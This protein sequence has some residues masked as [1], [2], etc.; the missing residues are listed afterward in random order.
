MSH[1]Q[2]VSS[3]DAV[4]A[5]RRRYRRS[6]LAMPWVGGILC[7]S[8][9][10]LLA[11]APARATVVHRFL[12]TFGEPGSAA[13]Q[14]K[15]PTYIAANDSIGLTPAAGDVYVIDSG[16]ARVERFSA[17]G[18]YLGQ[19]DGSG[20]YEVEGK[21]ETGP[22]APTGS[23]V[24][25]QEIA[26]DDSNSPGDPSSE[27]VYVIDE[28]HGVID[29]FTSTG[30]YVGQI[31]G[32]K[33]GPF[34]AGQGRA[35]SLTG[36]AVDSTGNLWVETE[37][38]PIYSFTDAVVN[39]EASEHSTEQGGGDKLLVGPESLLIFSAVTGRFV[40]T[41][42]SGKTLSNPFGGDQE[43]AVG[44]LDPLHGEVYLSDRKAIQ[45][46]D[47]NG[48][49]IESDRS[50]ALAPSFGAGH[51]TLNAGLGVNASN[52]TVYAT[53]VATDTVSVFEALTLPTVTLGEPTGRAPRGAIL[54]GTVNPEGKAV[55]ACAF[56]YDTRPY[57]QGEAAH[58]A[59]A[60]CSPAIVGSAGT[61]PIAVSASVGGLTPQRTYY[62]RL[63][64][65]NA[66]GRD[67]S[68]GAELFTGPRLGGEWALA[69]AS[70]SVTLRAQVDPNGGD[71]HYYFQ[72]GPS[73]AYGSYAP[74]EPPGTDIGSAEGAQ[75]VGAHLQGLEATA[76]YHYRFVAVQGGEE[77]A[78][79]DQTFTTQT[80]SATGAG[81]VDGRE[82]ELVSPPDK[83]GALIEVTEQG[84]PVQA[85][86]DG[87]GISY[88]AKGTKFGEQSRGHVTVAT[89][90]SKRAG[91]GWRSTDLTLPGSLPETGESAVG[92]A[93]YQ[94]E[95][96]LFSPQL[97]RAVVEPQ[98]GTPPLSP[99]AS[100]RTIYLRDDENDSFLA[101]VN[102]ANVPGGT[103]IQ[104]TG[105]GTQTEPNA[106]HV[107]FLTATPDLKHVVFKTPVALTPEATDEEHPT[108]S[109]EADP[110]EPHCYYPSQRIQWNI[111]EWSDGE[112]KLV[113]VLPGKA[114][115]AHG[116][117]PTAPGVRLAGKINVSGSGHGGA[118]RAISA[119]GRFIAWAWGQ[120]YTTEERQIY[121]GL[122][123][124]DMVEESTTRVGGAAAV[125]QTMSS[126]GAR[127][128]YLEGGELY[129]YDHASGKTTSLTAGHGGS[130][131]SGEVQETVS[132]VSE[133]GSY[134]YFVARGVL[135]SGGTRGEDNLYVSHDTPDGWATSWIATLAADDKPSWYATEDF[136]VPF[137]ADVSSRVSPDG[138]FLA[139]MSERPLTGYDNV[140][141]TSGQRDEEVFLY[142]AREGT[143]VCGSCN[144]TE[145]RPSG[146]LDAHEAQLVI[147]R[148]EVWTA[149][150]SDPY[151][152]RRD[153]WLA[154]SI[155]GWDNVS[156]DSPS[157]Q[158]RY[159][160]DSGRLFFD[161]AD[162]LVPHDTNGVED[163]YEFEP[164]GV[165]G[166]TSAT[167]SGTEVYVRELAGR[168]VGGCIGLLSAGTSGAESAFYDASESGDDVFFATRSKLV[169][170]DFDNGYDVYDAHVCTSAVPCAPEAVSPPP[171][172]SG[173]ACKGPPTPQPALFG[174]PASATFSGIGNVLVAPPSSAKQGHSAN[175]RKLATAL[176][177][178][179]RWRGK[180]RATCERQ[181]HRRYG[182]K[183]ARRTRRSGR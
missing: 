137:L 50:G 173:D 101:L 83:K 87:S 17:A 145:A 60:D 85:A 93:K 132:N 175:A 117:Y 119:D 115:V 27:D 28:G 32:T 131:P 12:T 2:E 10:F 66:A 31:T 36:V 126:D 30:A 3:H 178:C 20:T 125:Y 124:R 155:P 80:A 69:A 75:T 166:C 162:G 82:W 147:D 174:S 108:V 114:G 130:E 164:G 70:T 90:L 61:S 182:A 143:L 142:D 54:N 1:L 159:L 72:Y 52:A 176:R 181:A 150:S 55:T 168:P 71:T 152:P 68:A 122:Y 21:V 77:F 49:P 74:L 8:M 172:A 141:A 14:L 9:A 109:C 177:A 103:V 140:D 105:E 104:P 163:V 13:G 37:S 40:E 39:Q 183:S 98:P 118:P 133:D 129:V 149:K 106:W 81:L 151:N 16:N 79:P 23:F 160:S 62:Y 59:S 34:E 136:A 179:H 91:E 102:A 146:V 47:L 78:G 46:F 94:T 92:L 86:A 7:V 113:N 148:E 5:S 57:A 25:P 22:A 29:K 33:A 127:I 112:L 180:R 65:E 58:G 43:A 100:E 11:G 167:A 41:D 4:F 42:S 88:V 121:R 171:C 24:H 89:V 99:E 56:E 15:E 116:R 67:T 154:G 96:Y 157:Y 107:R 51:L 73:A 153:H 128:F 170:A 76:T 161:S 18:V 134:V 35:R 63:A 19:F 144:P 97:E 139:F 111:Y 110:A 64:A 45:A 26:V 6:R 156:E 120:P 165:G 53:D 123:L 48:N 84:G 138:R 135:A 38:N 158:P 44:S 95:V 169:G